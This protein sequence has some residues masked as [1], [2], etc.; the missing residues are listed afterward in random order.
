S[1]PFSTFPLSGFLPLP[2]TGF[3]DTLCEASFLRG[4]YRG[5]FVC[6]T[7]CHRG[8]LPRHAWRSH[9]LL[10]VLRCSGCAL[11][12]P[13]TSIRSNS[14]HLYPSSDPRQCALASG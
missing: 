8:L 14:W 7:R 9:S 2:V 5:L 6:L 12:P 4:L 10:V 1:E 11:R 3:L 13:L